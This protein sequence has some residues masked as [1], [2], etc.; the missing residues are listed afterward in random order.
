MSEAA[1]GTAMIIRLSVMESMLLSLVVLTLVLCMFATFLRRKRRDTAR[2]HPNWEIPAIDGHAADTSFFHT[3]HPAA[4][5]VSLLV[6]CFLVAS[7]KSLACSTAALTISIV[8]VHLSRLPWQR[9]LQ[10]LA[11]MSGFL[12]MFMIV[13]PFSSHPQPGETQILFPLL[14]DHPFRLHGFLLALTVTVKACAIALLMDPMFGTSPLAQTLH[15]LNRHGLP[16]AVSQMVLISHR[17]IFVFQQEMLRM[18]RSMRVR[19][20]AAGTDTATMRTMGNFFGMLFIS[21]FDRTQKVY[22]AMLCRGYSGT[23]PSSHDARAGARDWL[24]GGAWIVFGLLLL[25]AEH[26]PV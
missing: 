19:G 15:A 13:V 1:T 18:W 5:V 22:E 3:W 8:A 7:L 9:S 23:L 12:L 20:F 25:L 26:L 16:A 4:K 21:S 14:A 10:R 17:Y 2:N 24:K 6:Y 11:A